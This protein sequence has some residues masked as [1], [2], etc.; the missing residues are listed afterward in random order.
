M[1]S[2]ENNSL[3]LATG[4]GW[5]LVKINRIESLQ[6]NTSYHKEMKIYWEEKT[7]Y[8]AIQIILK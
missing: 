6:E 3:V 8:K 1:I 7:Y 2:A 4:W 5:M